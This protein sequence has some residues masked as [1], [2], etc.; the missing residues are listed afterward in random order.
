MRIGAQ[1]GA[2][3]EDQQIPAIAGGQPAVH[4][5]R[6]LDLNA[7]RRCRGIDVTVRQPERGADLG[8]RIT[9]QGMPAGTE[10]R[11]SAV[12]DGARVVGPAAQLAT[13]RIR[14]ERVNAPGRRDGHL[15]RG[16]VPRFVYVT[17]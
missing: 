14:D 13:V 7:L 15:V 17:E 4:R 5:S 11:A 10:L 9:G 1:A 6:R 16:D 2:H 3:V 12:P 8:S